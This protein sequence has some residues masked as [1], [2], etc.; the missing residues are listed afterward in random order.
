MHLRNNLP[1]LI[2]ENRS[3]CVVNISKKSS[4]RIFFLLLKYSQ[5]ITTSPN[6]HHRYKKNDRS[7]KQMFVPYCIW[8]NL[9]HWG[10]TLAYSAQSRGKSE[11]ENGTVTGRFENLLSRN[12]RNISL[13]W[14]NT[15]S[16]KKK[17]LF[18]VAGAGKNFVGSAFSAQVP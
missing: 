4:W 1:Q 5:T 15:E 16:A 7:S 9:G 2:F 18:L 11:R 14:F 8:E 6:F 17:L 13:L 10:A 3:A 12:I